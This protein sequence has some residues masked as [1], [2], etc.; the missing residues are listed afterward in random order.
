MSHFIEKCR[1]CA[2]VTSQCRCIDCN[3]EV[4]L[5]ICA[6][7]KHGIISLIQNK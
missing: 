4:R 5:V 2:K 3:K 6:D 7:V 1:R